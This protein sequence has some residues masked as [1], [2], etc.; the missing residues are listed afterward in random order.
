[1]RFVGATRWSDFGLFGER[2]RVKAERAASY[3]LRHAGTQQELDWP[4][5]ASTVMNFLKNLT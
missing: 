5:D 3:F 2:G 1:V 4:F